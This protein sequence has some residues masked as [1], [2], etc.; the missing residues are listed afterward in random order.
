MAKCVDGSQLQHVHGWYLAYNSLNLDG[1]W[2]TMDYCCQYLAYDGLLWLVLGLRW[3]IVAGT[4]P[5]MDY[6]SWYLG[7]NSGLLFARMDYMAGT[8]GHHGG[9]QGQ[10]SFYGGINVNKGL[11]LV[12]QQSG[13]PRVVLLAW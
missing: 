12:T 5:T 7:Y 10:Y 3:I 11:Q 9:L 4:W 2:A 1:T 6:Y 13:G 8:K